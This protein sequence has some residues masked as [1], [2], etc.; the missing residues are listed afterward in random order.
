[1][2]IETLIILVTC[3]LCSVQVGLGISMVIVRNRMDRHRAELDQFGRELKRH[4]A[5]LDS[6]S[7][8]FDELFKLERM[9]PASGEAVQLLRDLAAWD[10]KEGFHNDPVWRRLE[11]AIGLYEPDAPTAITPEDLWSALAL[12]GGERPEP[13]GTNEDMIDE[14]DRLFAMCDPAK[15][16]KA[17]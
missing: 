14:W 10:E 15:K 17:D 12:A 11:V 8:A 16:G 4:G 7:T 13:D 5:F 3:C 6:H 2:N 1:M 9:K